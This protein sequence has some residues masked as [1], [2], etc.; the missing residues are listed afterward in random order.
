LLQEETS[1]NVFFEGTQ[2]RSVRATDQWDP[3]E[4]FAVLEP[5]FGSDR[6]NIQVLIRAS[7][8]KDMC[9]MRHDFRLLIRQNVQASTL[10][11][12]RYLEDSH[13][14]SDSIGDICFWKPD[15]RRLGSSDVQQQQEYRS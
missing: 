7:S 15:A 10:A 14:G 6:Q 2:R 3:S 8:G 11:E 12:M 13:F 4:A 1:R 5:D 9:L